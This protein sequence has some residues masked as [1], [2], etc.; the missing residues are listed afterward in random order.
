MAKPPKSNPHSDLDGVHQDERPN[1]AT[2][3]E[4]GETAE[5]LKLAREESKGRPEQRP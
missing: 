1:V 3:Q 4:A 2:A 5:D